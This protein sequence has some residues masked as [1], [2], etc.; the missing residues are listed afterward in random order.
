M[1]KYTTFLRFFVGENF[2]KSCITFLH[3]VGQSLIK[4]REFIYWSRAE[5]TVSTL[6]GV[7][8][9]TAKWLETKETFL[10]LALP[11]PS[12]RFPICFVGQLH[13]IFL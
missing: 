10:C 6:V 9:E 1:Y 2:S 8:R 13:H 7:E 4:S 11:S 5:R 12:P 3:V